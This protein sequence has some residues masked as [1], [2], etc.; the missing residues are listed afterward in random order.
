MLYLLQSALSALYMVLII[1]TIPLAFDLGGIDCGIN[2]TFTLVV[3]YFLMSTVRIISR[4]TKVS[5]L[6]SLLYYSQHIVLPTLLIIHLGVAEHQQTTQKAPMEGPLFNLYLIP[7]ESLV[8]PWK[9]LVNYSTPLFTITEGFCT[10]LCIQAA[11]QIARWLIRKNDNWMFLQIALSGGFLSSALYFLYRIYTFPLGVDLAS[12]TMIGVVLTI[13]MGLGF[14]GII[15]GKGSAIESSLLVSYVVYC[16]YIMF[17]DFESPKGWGDFS[18]SFLT[19]SS[20]IS[21]PPLPPTLINGY[22]NVMTTLAGMIPQSFITV[23]EFFVAVFATVSPS[24]LFSLSYRLAVFYAATRIIPA[25]A[26]SNE[27]KRDSSSRPS[28]SKPILFLV[29]AYAPIII[30]A[31]YTHLLMQHI[32][33]HTTPKSVLAAHS[34]TVLGLQKWASENDLLGISVAS[35]QLWSWINVIVFLTFYA[36]ELIYGETNDLMENH[37]KTD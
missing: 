22:S 23:G 32:D 37:L 26:S 17:T 9:L 11:G 18:T 34:F 27:A 12:A 33:R 20:D 28:K 19:G 7:Y 8:V 10:L 31:E 14:F 15:S 36:L 5:I 25:L 3:Y 6:G 13:T 21:V 24:V 30:I 29:Y 2:Y 35:W 1:T 4:K 16:L